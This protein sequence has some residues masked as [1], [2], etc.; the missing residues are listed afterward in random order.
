MRSSYN[1]IPENHEDPVV[2][3]R[4]EQ[5]FSMKSRIYQLLGATI[6]IAAVVAV[7]FSSK[8]LLRSSTTVLKSS[9][10]GSL[11]SQMFASKPNYPVEEERK[12][13]FDDFILKHGKTYGSESE[14]LSRF[15]I[16]KD[17]LALI[18]SRAA[19]E[20]ASGG[21]AVHGITSFADLTPKEFDDLLT[22]D[23]P[24]SFQEPEEPALMQ[25]TTA[26]SSDWR[27]S[28]VTAI[29]NQGSCGCCWAYASTEQIESDAI[30][31]LS[32]FD[33]SLNLSP[34]QLVDCDR[35]DH[36]CNGG[37][38]ESA[39]KYVG[40]T[41]GVEFASDYPSTK[42][43]GTCASNSGKYI[44]GVSGYTG[45]YSNEAWMQNY[46][47]TTGPLAACLDASSISTYTSGIISSCPTSKC[48]HAIQLVGINTASSPAYWIV[49]DSFIL[50]RVTSM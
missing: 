27:S 15:E 39:W 46:V 30:R 21:F 2:P 8:T 17:N 13:L 20:K 37:W 12:Q 7:T 3:F 11:H 24:S 40:S 42:K 44:V 10:S 41:G 18:A 47:L 31:T 43:N 19:Q 34:Q 36:A 26:T 6:F 35:V 38:M 33:P 9:E 14:Y 32:G 29:K 1:S 45:Y 50:N 22:L 4:D 16:F 25:A 28:Y 48:N 5:A 49:S 23:P